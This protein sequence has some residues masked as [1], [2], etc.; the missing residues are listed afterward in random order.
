MAHAWGRRVALMALVLLSMTACSDQS[1]PVTLT[2]QSISLDDQAV[3]LTVQADSLG[4]AQTQI[5][6]ARATLT[7]WPRQAVATTNALLGA[8]ATLQAQA[9]QE[10][11]TQAVGT[12]R[13]IEAIMRAGAVRQAES[14]AATD[15][16][17]Q[18]AT[19]EAGGRM[20]ATAAAG[21][22]FFAATATQA[23]GDLATDIAGWQSAATLDAGAQAT[24]VAG[25]NGTL[26]V[27]SEALALAVAERDQISLTATRQALDADAIDASL[28]LS[29]TALAG[30]LQG[31]LQDR[32]AALGTATALAQVVAAAR[33]NGPP[34]LTA[35]AGQYAT[36]IAGRDADLV[37]RA[38]DLATTAADRD[39]LRALATEGAGAILAENAALVAALT[40][41]A[42]F[43]TTR[44]ADLTL[45]LGTQA[46]LIDTL[47]AP[48][49]VPPSPTATFTPTP[50]SS[51]TPSPSA[52]LSPSPTRTP[53]AT[54]T[55]TA[56][57]TPTVTNSPTAT[58]SPTETPTVTPTPTPESL[59]WVFV[60]NEVGVNVRQQASLTAPIVWSAEMGTAMQ[61][62]RIEADAQG[63]RW[64]QVT[65]DR[66][67]Q[68]EIRGWVLGEVVVEILP[69]PAG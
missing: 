63:R 6:E 16:A 17:I 30:D 12:A 24:E 53:T 15:L 52:T 46:A 44:I 69:C 26:A 45:R 62:R 67:G 20:L 48:T 57:L 68:G 2:A 25:L 42:D 56:T 66:A 40:E 22:A 7:A 21:Q 64:Y 1:V 65:V 14:I 43:Q 54:F 19:I 35:Q 34:A 31:A 50:T 39:R 10:A 27:Q 47:Q 59:C 8:G 61:V 18:Q 36:D 38:N 9:V 55:L 3:R 32:D 13:S 29:L 49:A 11:V 37:A 4:G 28:E 5:A 33:V 51:M 23:I 60:Q 58:A 41:Q